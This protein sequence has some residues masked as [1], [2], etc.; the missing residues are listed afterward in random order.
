M[1]RRSFLKLIG[2]TSVWVAL[3]GPNAVL[4]AAT[5]SAG[6][7]SG[8]VGTTSGSLRYKAD[9]GTILVSSDNG[10]TWTLHTNL[11]SMYRVDKLA[12][13]KS[14]A[15]EATVAYAGRA[16]GLRLAPNLQSWLTV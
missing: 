16:F 6:S 2:L 10:R 7:G 13:G 5:S 8:G 14:G 9:G 15:V 11:G 3:A 12:A 4:G 1:R